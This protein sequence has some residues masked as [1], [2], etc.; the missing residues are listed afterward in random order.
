MPKSPLLSKKHS[1]PVPNKNATQPS[2]APGVTQGSYDVIQLEEIEVLR[3]I[4]GEDFEDVETKK[5]WSKAIERSFRLKLR[6]NLNSAVCVVLN[7]TL[8]PTYP[9]SVP[10]LK[11]TDVSNVRPNALGQIQNV[12]NEKPKALASS[13]EVMIFELASDVQG[14]LDD[15]VSARARNDQLPSLEE[16]RAV[17]EAIAQESARADEEQR[18]RQEEEERSALEKE[19]QRRLNE[20]VRKREEAQQRRLA[21]LTEK[22]DS[23]GSG[24]PFEQVTFDQAVSFH[25]ELRNQHRFRSVYLFRR[26]AEASSSTVATATP[27]SAQPNSTCFVIKRLKLPRSCP[28]SSILELENI[29]ERLKVLRHA[30]VINI[31]AFKL[32]HESADWQCD[33]LTEFATRSTLTE[34]LEM[35]GQL[36][37]QRGRT[38]TIELLQALDFYHKHG[39]VHGRIHTGNV[40]FTTLLSGITSVKLADAGFE[41]LVREKFLNDNVSSKRSGRG[42]AGWMAPELLQHMNAEKSRKSDIWEMGVIL[43]QMFLGLET[44]SLYASPSKLISDGRLSEPFEDLLEDV[45][46]NEPR[47]RPGPFDIVPYEFLRTDC[48]VTQHNVS[49]RKSRTTSSN[50]VSAPTPRRLLRSESSVMTTTA[51][52]WNTEWEEIGR[53][54]KGGYGE[55][56]KARN[57]LD[58]R[59]YAVKKISQ[60]SPSELNQVLSEVYLLATLNHPYVVRY[61]TAFGEEQEDDAIVDSSVYT[62]STTGHGIVF[63]SDSEDSGQEDPMT[64]SLGGLDFIS[65]SGYP[66]I[67]FGVDS[68]D[69]DDSDESAEEQDASSGSESPRVESE[70]APQSSLSMSLKSKGQRARSFS[71]VKIRSTLYIQMEFCERLTLRDMIRKTMSVEAVWLLFRQVL[72]GL[73]HIHTHGIIHRDL[74]PENIFIDAANNPRIGDFGLATSS[75]KSVDTQPDGPVP[76]DDMTR[77]VGTTLYVAPEL[78]TKGGGSYTDKIDMYSLGIIL[79]EMSYTLPT[80]M[81]RVQTL[82]SLR[83]KEHILP[84]AFQATEKTLQAEVIT[85]LITHRPSERPTSA[86]LLQSGKIPV[87]VEDETIRLALKGLADDNSPYHHKIISALFSRSGNADIKAQLWDQRKEVAGSSSPINFLLVQSLVKERLQACFR[88]HGAVEVQRNGLFPRSDHY[89]EAS[90]VQLLDASGTLVQLPHDLTLPH[91]RLVAKQNHVAEKSFT[92]GMVYRP[93]LMGTA[94]RSN[95][96]MDFDIVSHTG[97]DLVLQ[98]A[99]V[100]KVMDEVLESFPS[101]RRAPMCYHVSHARLLDIILD[102]CRISVGQRQAVKQVLGRLN[103]HQQTWA[104]TRLELRS[105]SIAVSSTSLDELARFDFRETPENC[106]TKIMSIFDGTQYVPEI[107]KLFTQ[108][109]GLFEYCQRLGVKRKIYLS[110]LSNFNESFYKEGIMFQCIFDTKKRDVLAAGGRYDSLIDE[111]RP[112]IGNNDP[113]SIVH[114]VGVNIGFDT[115]VSS[116]VRHLKDSGGSAFLKKTEETEHQSAWLIRRCDVLIA[117]FEPSVLRSTGLGLVSKLWASD[118]SAEMAVDVRSPEQLGTHYR[119]DKH[120]WIIT[121]KHEDIAS[122]KPDLKVKSVDKKVDYDIRSSDLVNF[123]RAEIRERDQREGTNERSKM[124]HRQASQPADSVTTLASDRRT[125]VQVLLANHKSKKGNKWRII[126]QAQHK[127]QELLRIY[128]DGP[129]ACVETRDEIVEMI[130]Q[131]KLSDT[132]GWRRVA[133]DANLS[134]RQYVQEVWDLLKEFK[135]QYADP[136]TGQGRN[137]FL[138]NF[139]SGMMIMYD[140]LL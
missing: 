53:L 42:H 138:F 115:I 47:R 12:I 90:V 22:N 35:V 119:E 21:E 72:E 27:T 84:E 30:S 74:K 129:I 1:I 118:I 37:A 123:L 66:K 44:T 112:R 89:N 50:H 56:V 4:Y 29:L 135:L 77:N 114:G 105:A 137:C 18:L 33:I 63:G 31:L 11:L 68:D 58:G 125:D 36:P 20:E 70:K 130:R 57:K 100:I 104:K 15:E 5:A 67:E 113:T 116:M 69:D 54:G 131:T 121:I 98:E 73:V 46:S 52:R 79:F 88:R 101:L 120:S 136:A 75:Q 139:R 109:A 23:E 76:E 122:D 106:L 16:E 102:F 140:L 82:S 128:A 2:N 111:H 3:S 41:N 7:V 83:K 6:S 80:A 110:P 43:V 93:N 28:K 126:E 87:Q 10:S 38:F 133:Q 124:L 14:V 95:R 64:Q 108:M 85:S 26:L 40:M 13:G 78:L 55:V 99:E 96:E 59:I 17:R 39:I 24:S 45:F 60:K 49:A 8:G 51:S 94:P 34:M 103:I 19:N 62:E 48:S 97:K 65:S 81:E 91:A 71:R 132:E 92:F 134:E 32:S 117:S 86:Q 61:Y 25:D 127:A 9:K 107:H